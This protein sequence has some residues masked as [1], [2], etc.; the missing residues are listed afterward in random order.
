MI[1]LQ[2]IVSHNSKPQYQKA[3]QR[4]PPR[5]AYRVY[6]IAKSPKPECQIGIVDREKLRTVQKP[7]HVSANA[8]PGKLKGLVMYIYMFTACDV[9]DVNRRAGKELATRTN[10]NNANH[11]DNNSN[12]QR[13]N[14]ENRGFI[15]A[16]LD[17]GINY[18]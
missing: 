12:E 9:L 18:T 8:L 16:S 5:K 10:D 3:S 14:Q 7:C 2:L 1:K 15:S 17:W 11:D 13:E 6:R 4:T